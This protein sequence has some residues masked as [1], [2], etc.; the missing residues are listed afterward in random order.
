M[1]FESEVREEVFRL[2]RPDTRWLSTGFGGGYRDAPAAYNVTVPTGFDRTD[3][4][5][6]LRERRRRVGFDADGPGLL[7]GVAMRHV[8]GARHG[9][10]AAYATAGVSNPAVLAV[11]DER[12]DDAPTRS[13][14][15]DDPGTTT[16]SPT[17]DDSTTTDDHPRHDGT[18]NVVVATTRALDDGVLA[19]LLTTVVEAKTATLLA[20]TGFTGTTTDA[21]IV[22]TATDGEPA[23][24]AGAAT[25]VGAAAR[26]CV[27]RAVTATVSARYAD[28][29]PPTAVADA[30]YGVVTD[31]RATAFD[32]RSDDAW[33]DTDHTV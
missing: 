24:F 23:S 19:E 29:S 25:T 11:D 7:T 22:G 16:S 28:A 27:R 30:D 17:S 31:E 3:L 13:T 8:R 21:V 5:A 14:P 15:D 33:S 6:Y 2:R 26:A 20:R 10:V 18:V 4:R 32:P 1:P 12:A 9:P